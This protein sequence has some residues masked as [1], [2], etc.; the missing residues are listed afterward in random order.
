MNEYNRTSDHRVAVQTD[1][2]RFALDHTK[3]RHCRGCMGCI[4]N[5][6][7]FV[8]MTPEV[9]C[10]GCRERI[11]ARCLKVGIPLPWEV[12]WEIRA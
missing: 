10:I 5:P 12:E 9:W 7:W 6:A 3:H 11:R 4:I 1:F 8:Q 2:E